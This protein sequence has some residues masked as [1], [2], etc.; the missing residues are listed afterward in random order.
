MIWFDLDD[1]SLSF[2]DWSFVRIG[3]GWMK[4]SCVKKENCCKKLDII[5]Y[6]ILIVNIK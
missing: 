2:S 6:D 5:Y 3:C 1:A 4:Y